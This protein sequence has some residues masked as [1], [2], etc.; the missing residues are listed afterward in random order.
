MGLS[1]FLNHPLGKPALVLLGT[2][3]VSIFAFHGT[4]LFWP[5]NNPFE[6]TQVEISKGASL[7]AIG[8]KLK[9]QKILTNEKTFLMAAKILGHETNI[10]AGKFTL[11][12]PKNNYQIIHQLAKKL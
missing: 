7:A 1:P 9:E 4:I 8:S 10:P 2:I 12:D 3:V 5:Q 11:L 6:T